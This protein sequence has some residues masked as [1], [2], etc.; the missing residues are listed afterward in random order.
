MRGGTLVDG[1]GGWAVRKNYRTPGPLIERERESERETEREREGKGGREK[2]GNVST[3]HS[4][5]K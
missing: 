2:I 4:E 1:P 3:W 5:R